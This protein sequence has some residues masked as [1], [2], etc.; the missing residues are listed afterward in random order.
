[1]SRAWKI[2]LLLAVIL[3]LAFTV[4]LAWSAPQNEAKL[5]AFSAKELQTSAVNLTK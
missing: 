5:A 4:S 1:M 3:L 2:A